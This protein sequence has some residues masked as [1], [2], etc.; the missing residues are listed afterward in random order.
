M[1]ASLLPSFPLFMILP[2]FLQYFLT[3]KLIAQAKKI[4]KIKNQ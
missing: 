3:A 4:H 2:D 1:I